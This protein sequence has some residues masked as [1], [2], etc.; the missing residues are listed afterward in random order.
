MSTLPVTPSLVEVAS[1]V[2]EGPRRHV[3]SMLLVVLLD[4]SFFLVLVFGDGTM[5]AVS[6]GGFGDETHVGL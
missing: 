1:A 4:T 5:D 3:V 6:N 2:R